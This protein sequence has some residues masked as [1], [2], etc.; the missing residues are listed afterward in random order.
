MRL[1]RLPPLGGGDVLQWGRPA[2]RVANGPA[3]RHQKTLGEFQLV[4][5]S[6]NPVPCIRGLALFSNVGGKAFSEDAAVFNI[7]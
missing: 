7:L 5:P 4:F 6:A 1:F 2:F 3:G